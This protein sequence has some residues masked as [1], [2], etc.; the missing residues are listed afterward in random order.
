MSQ[1]QNDAQ[2]PVLAWFNPA[3]LTADT[4]TEP[5][6]ALTRTPQPMVLEHVLQR[7]SLAERQFSRLGNSGAASLQL[8]ALAG[9]PEV[10]NELLALQQAVLEQ[11]QEIQSGWV[12]GWSAWFQSF[13]EVRRAN[14]MSK[15]L[16]QEFNMLGQAFKLLQGQTT[17]LVNFQDNV[18]VNY[19]YWVSQ[20]LRAHAPAGQGVTP[21]N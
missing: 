18:E 8:L 20:Q 11:A 1:D 12:A 6:S 14:T 21:T 4:T 13:G 15:L 2:N 9:K 3:A 10:W 19:A 17:D 5:W 7:F 16:E